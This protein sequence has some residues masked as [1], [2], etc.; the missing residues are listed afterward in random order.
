MTPT[1][2]KEELLTLAE[3]HVRAFFKDRIDEKYVYHD[4]E[5]TL[6]V[7]DAAR[8]ISEYFS[9]NER[10]H[11]LLKLAALFHDTGY[12]HG[13]QDHESRSASYARTFLEKH[14]APEADI[15]VV[16]ECILATRF[17]HQPTTL[18]QQVLCDADLA[19]LGDA[20]YW[21]RCGRVRQELATVQNIL[22]SEPEWVDFELQFMKKHRYFTAAAE[23]LYGAGKRKHLKQLNKQKKRLHPTVKDLSKIDEP[24]K[25][26]KS[27]KKKKSKKKR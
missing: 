2:T 11:R 4:L 8:D 1:Q 16:E 24:A 12:D 15:K 18:L 22:M 21:D 27:P 19:H 25:G 3:Q 20:T 9:L 5:H 7:R 10:E 17:P 6:N 13:P 26:Q 14:E 23:E